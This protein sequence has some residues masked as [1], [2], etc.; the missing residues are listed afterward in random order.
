MHFLQQKQ[1]QRFSLN[2]N[3]LKDRALFLPFLFL[4]KL[5]TRHVGSEVD[6]HSHVAIIRCCTQKQT[7][8]QQVISMGHEND[9]IKSVLD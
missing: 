4:T 2:S 5:N 7:H 9:L 3:C 1:F 8:L 6:E